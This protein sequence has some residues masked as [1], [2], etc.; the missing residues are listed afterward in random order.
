MENFIKN[1]NIRMK[2]L[3]TSINNGIL[4]DYDAK[5]IIE[6]VI[7]TLIEVGNGTTDEQLHKACD[8]LLSLRDLWFDKRINQNSNKKKEL[9]INTLVVFDEES[10]TK[11]DYEKY[12]KEHFPYRKT[13]VYLGEI[14][15][16]K[17]HCILC[18]LNS[19]KIIGMC[20]T[21]NFRE[22]TEDE[23]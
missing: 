12:Y 7:D 17:G 14:K 16:V 15:Q 10:C 6:E 4:S 21:E 5:L 11:D 22:A 3:E 20:H 8:Y 9:E 19:G 18:D 13:F 2:Q 23:Y 1:A